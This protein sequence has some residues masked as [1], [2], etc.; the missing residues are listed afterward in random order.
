MKALLL[1][2]LFIGFCGFSF[3]QNPFAVKGVIADTASNIKLVNATIAILNSKDSTLVKF[4]RAQA[5]GEFSISNLKKGKFI[6]LVSYPAYADYVETFQLDSAKK[7]RNVGNI[8]MLL[9]ERLLKEVMIKGKAAAI[10]IKGD[11]TEFNASSFTIQPNSK[12]EDLLKQL[13]GIQVDKDGKITAQGQAVNK[14]LV[15]GEEFFGDDPTLVTKNIR[16][17]M[18]DKVQLY[19]K[20]SD[21]ATF[22]GIDDGV[23]NKT[24]NIKL[25]EDKKNGYFGKVA[26]GVGTDGYYQ[27]QGMYN[28]FKAKQKFSAYGTLANTGKIGLGW[29]DNSKYA[30]SN[31][32]EFMD[33]GGIMITNNGRDELDSFDGRYNN[34]G[35]PV[36]RTGGAHYDTKWN[37]DKESI[38]A[39]YKIGS[40]EVD[41]TS[42]TINQNNLPTGIQNRN[43]TQAFNNSIFRQKLDAIYQVKL[44][45]ASSL[46]LTIDGTLRNS[47]TKSND[48]STSYAGFD[49]LLNRSNR[50]LVNNSDGKILNASAFYTHKFKKLGRSFS[51]A[52][53]GTYNEN[54]TKGYLNSDISF[55]NRVSGLVDSIQLINQYKT[56]NILSRLINTNIT[57]SEPFT[58]AFSVIVNYG[59]SFNS[60]SADRRSFD[61]T[62]VGEYT[63][64]NT[65]LSN[66]YKLNQ[67]SNQVGAVFNYKKGKTILNFGSRVASVNFEQINQYTN[68]SF[69]RDFINWSPQASYQYKF[70]QQKS[71]S[72]Y[73][74]G[75]TT[76][77]TIDQIQ[78][79]LINTDPL[80]LFLGNPDLRPSF[81][82]RVNVNF[83]SYKILSEQNIYLGASYGSTLNAIVNNTTTNSSGKTTYQYSNLGNKN[84]TNFNLYSYFSRKIKKLNFNA[85]FNLNV[86]GNTSYNYTNGILNKTTS[87]TYGGSLNLNKYKE[88][89]YEMYLNIGPTYTVSGSSLQPDINNNGFGANGYYNFK[90][91]LPLKFEVGFDG[92]YEYRAKTQSFNEDYQRIIINPMIS[93][94]FLKQ[95]GLKLSIS[96]N[97]LLN[98][99]VGFNRS[100]YAGNI[101]Q[102]SYTTIRRYFMVFLSYDFNKMGGAKTQKQ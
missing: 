65:A 77:P 31:N 94:K 51:M 82:N 9:K 102:T 44:D 85:G 43:S 62:T 75:N 23:K 26:A 17:D 42:N 3:A 60:S 57:Y 1:L 63:A 2:L 4:T 95:D 67:T 5:N 73:Y 30:S 83:N 86:Y 22:T 53:N 13:P 59:L 11:T 98:Q 69:K 21:Q 66:N 7:E 92:N 16:G 54:H 50:S 41:G 89:K 56:S 18:V 84:Q 71:L 34:Q 90:V 78:P 38:N 61:Q 24:I 58:K 81:S 28:R 87:Y 36:A 33:G 37:K 68:S 6:L 46:K 15:D 80:N 96:A 55:Y 8:N 97:D 79:V 10:K 20:K 35:I 88:K 25:K 48:L 76:Q 93:K 99:N 101:T 100:A 27:G 29:E 14:V 32:V 91:Y 70:S 40:L 72:V 19:D 49:T 74:N 45:T 12:V 39:N 47:E 64:L 52:V